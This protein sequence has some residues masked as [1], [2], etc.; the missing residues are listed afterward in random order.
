MTIFTPSRLDGPDQTL[1]TTQ[2]GPDSFMTRNLGLSIPFVRDDSGRVVRFLN[3][4]YA[5]DRV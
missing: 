4:G 1:V 2:V 3:G 5:Y